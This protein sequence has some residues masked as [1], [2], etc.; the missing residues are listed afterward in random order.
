MS[1]SPQDRTIGHEDDK[2]EE[3]T[4][5]KVQADDASEEN[6]GE[7]ASEGGDDLFGAGDED[8]DDEDNMVVSKPARQKR[9]IDS[10][11]PSPSPTDQAAKSRARLPSSPSSKAHS[12]TP[13]SRSNQSYTALEHRETSAEPPMGIR[14]AE[15]AQA[16]LQEASFTLPSLPFRRGLPHYFA[17][18]PNLLQYRSEVF[19]EDS[20]DEV[21]EDEMLQSKDGIRIDDEGLR[22][23]LTTSNT[24]RWRWTDKHDED[25]VRVSLVYLQRLGVTCPFHLLTHP[26]RYLHRYRNQTLEL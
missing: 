16:E 24:I 10:A 25:G 12:P 26:E 1:E 9:Q 3:V 14:N 20:F 8:D 7:E 18:L 5:R 6:A 22:S 2:V 15:G 19:D 4:T 11:S 23:L 17:R 21:K 13:S